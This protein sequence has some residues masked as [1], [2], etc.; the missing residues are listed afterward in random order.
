MYQ[1][2]LILPE[3]TEDEQARLKEIKVY[4]TIFNICK[5]FNSAS[6]AVDFIEYLSKL[7]NCNYIIINQLVLKAIKK[8]P[9]FVPRL[10]EVHILLY[11]AGYS[12]RNINKITGCGNNKIYADLR[13]YAEQPY[14]F[15]K[16][17]TP[18]QHL[19]LDKLIISLE[20]FGGCI[21]C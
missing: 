19:E 12:V 16:T 13:K 4:L 3:L 2:Q 20:K 14:A 18:V 17:L 11:R 5:Q 10:K 6:V 9:G 15:R 8:D 21:V 7:E 1:K